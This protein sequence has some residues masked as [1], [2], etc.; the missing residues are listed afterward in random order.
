[1]KKETPNKDYRKIRP[2]SRAIAEKTGASIDYVR[3]V[4]AGA[5][6]GR[7]DRAHKYALVVAEANKLLKAINQ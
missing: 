7:T 4:L 5:R 1:M 6:V 3:K 2:M